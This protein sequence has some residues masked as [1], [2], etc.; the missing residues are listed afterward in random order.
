M[1]AGRLT[2]ATILAMR[3]LLALLAAACGSTARVD[4]VVDAPLL[5]APPI[6]AAP[7]DA[8]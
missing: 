7:V 2:V 5:D 8:R 6:D 4:A 3:C 1:A